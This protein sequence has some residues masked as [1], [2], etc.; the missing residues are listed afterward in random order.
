MATIVPISDPNRTFRVWAKKD[1][2]TGENTGGAYVPNVDDMVWDWN[3]GIWRVVAVDYSTGLSTLLFYN[4]DLEAQGV[5]ENDILIG[6]GP[7]NNTEAYRV[8]VD[9]TV[10]PHTLAVDSRLHYKGTTVSKVRLFR[11]TDFTSASNTVISSFYDQSGTL[12]GD[13]IPVE[14]VAMPAPD[15][16]PEATIMNYAIKTPMV[17]YTNYTLLDGEPVTCV[18]Y[19][20]AGGVRSIARLMVQNSSFVRTTNAAMKYIT[21]IELNSPFISNSD[22]SVL[23]V[24]VNLPIASL[25]LKAKVYYSNGDAVELPVDGTK[26]RVLGLDSVSTTIPAQ[27]IPV[28]LQYS[29]GLNEYSFNTNTGYGEKV[30]AHYSIITKDVE[31]AYGIKLFPYPTW[32]ATNRVYTLRWFIYTMERN[33]WYEVTGLVEGV[34]NT[35]GYNPLAYN[36]IQ[37]LNVAV[38]M[39]SVSGAYKNYRH[40]QL[41]GV[42]LKGPLIDNTSSWL[43]Y[44]ELGASG[45]TLLPP[46]LTVPYGNN[47][48]ANSTQIAGSNLK[49]LDVSAGITSKLLWVDNLYR[50]TNPIADSRV[51]VRPPDPTHFYIRVGNTEIFRSIDQFNEPVELE[52]DLQDG[53]LVLL[54]FIRRLPTK[55]LELSIA[56]MQHRNI[57]L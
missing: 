18:A 55:D 56:G 16:L 48:W 12:L 44:H 11:G 15:T 43:I 21:S 37:E 54:R 52:H 14:L 36:T 20:D 42:Y 25:D 1:I 17:G 22:A 51:E 46:N 47:I 50:R 49:Q 8:F 13:T 5:T 4:R 9:H 39:R 26:F 6:I 32:D 57:S 40:S 31:G 29:I 24:P 10:T 53:E 19:D 38:N 23:E 30:N 35:P 41:V 27:K 28:M 45:N 34:T 3:T 7:G 2:Y 33:V